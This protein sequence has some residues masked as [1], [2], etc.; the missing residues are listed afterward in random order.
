[1][2]LL[3]KHDTFYVVDGRAPLAA[4]CRTLLI[5]S[6]KRAVWAKWLTQ[7]HAARLVAPVFTLRELLECRAACYPGVSEAR[8]HA[9][10][11]RW[12][13]SARFV[14]A[15][16]NEQ[17]QRV[18]TSELR[19]SLRSSDLSSAF[20]AIRLADTGLDEV[21]H[22]MVHMLAVDDAFVDYTLGFA[23]D[24]M[25]DRVLCALVSRAAAAVRQFIAA[26]A[27]SPYMA[28][29]RG[30]LFE[31]V[32]LAALASGTRVRVRQLLPPGAP[33]APSR[34]DVEEELPA[35]RVF[36]FHSAG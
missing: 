1:M 9:L 19:A 31:G 15:Q 2:Q 33:R 22:R 21:P 23:S 10:H 6:P 16:S 26:A 34:A 28:A 20:D 36:D 35:R 13:G 12:G 17:E 7:H 5:T 4:L 29:L 18:L 27:P 3:L 30:H 14:L 11:A 32:A 8:V 25:V 24:Y